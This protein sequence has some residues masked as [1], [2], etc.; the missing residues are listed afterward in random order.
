[1]NNYSFQDIANG[2]YG[3]KIAYTNVE[4][5]DE[6]NVIKVLG[7]NIGVFNSNKTAVQYLW[8]YKNGDQPI[9]YREKTI[10]DD[11]NNIV[12]ENHAWEIV[13]FK[14]GQTFGEPVQFVSTSKDEKVNENVELLNKLMRKVFK[15]RKDIDS[16]E[17]TS[18]VGFGYKAVQIKHNKEIP[19]GITVPTPMNTFIIYS[20]NSGEPMMAVQELKDADNHTYYL[21]F[22]DTH[23]FKIQNSKLIPYG[24]D[25]NGTIVKSKLHAF[26]GIPIVEIP[27]NQSRIS[28]IE[29]VIDIL[30]A[31]NNMQSNRMDAIE[32]FV[33]SW[34]KFVNCDV[35]EETFQKMKTAGALVVKSNNGSDNKADVDIMSQ[36]L[37]QQ[38]SQIAKDDLWDNALS[39]LAIPNRSDGSGD[40]QGA[41]FLKNGWDFSK[42]SAMLKDAYVVESETRLAEIVLNV[43]AIEKGKNYC[44]LTTMDFEV[45]IVHSPTDNLQVKTQSLQMLLTMGIHPLV[46]VKTSGLWSDAEKVF[47]LSKPYM[48]NLYKTIDDAI[49][50]Q[51]L[52]DQLDKANQL[53]NQNLTN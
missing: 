29:L 23:E 26:G 24:V 50:Q 34:V 48:D 20:S 16:G 21:C 1:M 9:R 7:S 6:S 40:R 19:F 5:I 46:A 32:Q 37:N 8:D 12:V 42:Q 35:D 52:Q 44:P 18:A 3:R 36:E 51:G 31:L 15:Q 47:N 28:D 13:R 33:Q 25:E 27:N 4:R 53:L 45:N 2:K 22:T 38:Q 43:L 11:V 10:R 30:D 41:T 39:I 17:W 49:E 14:N